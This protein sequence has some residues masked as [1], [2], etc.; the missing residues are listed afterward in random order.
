MTIDRPTG[1]CVFGDSVMMPVVPCT[2]FTFDKPAMIYGPL[3]PPPRS[4][5]LRIVVI[6]S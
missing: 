6:L 3:A 4:M 1:W 5:A 2:S